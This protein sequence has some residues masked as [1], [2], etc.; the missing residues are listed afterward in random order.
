VTIDWWTLGLQTV[1]VVILIWLLQRFFWKPVAGMIADRRVLAQK[2]LVEARAARDKA[3]SD[4][5]DI[6]KTRAGFAAERDKILAEARGDS[7]RAGAAKLAE[8]AQQVAALVAGAKVSAAEDAGA[9]RLAWASRSSDL[10]VDIAKRLA[11]RLDGPAVHRV[12]LDW[13]LK[14]IRALP[15]STREAATSAPLGLETTSATP[16]DP[17]EQEQA[18]KLIGEA[19]GA[20]ILVAF[21]TDAELIAGLEIRTDH[22]VVSNSWRADLAQILAGLAHEK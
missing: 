12:F 15:A 4:L 6:D 2:V 7:E 11:A 19:F 10:A 9:A 17:T 8:A 22:L 18:T 14:A 3:K 5:V 21:K 16:L 13:A 1:N 20:P